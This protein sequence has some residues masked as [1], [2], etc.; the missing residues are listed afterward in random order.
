MGRPDHWVNNGDKQLAAANQIPATH[1]ECGSQIGQ[2]MGSQ[3]GHHNV[4]RV[5][6]RLEIL[7]TSLHH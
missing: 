6:M 2:I 3:P 4:E 5:G 7:E 1:I